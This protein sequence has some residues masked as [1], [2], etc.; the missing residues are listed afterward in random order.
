MAAF[1]LSFSPVLVPDQLY[2]DEQYLKT[3]SIRTSMSLR[4]RFCVRSL[5][6][7]FLRD[8]SGLSGDP[9]IVHQGWALWRVAVKKLFLKKGNKMQKMFFEDCMLKTFFRK[10]VQIGKVK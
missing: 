4:N 7:F 6:D 5:L 10:T 1:P 8:A 9:S 2:L 3:M